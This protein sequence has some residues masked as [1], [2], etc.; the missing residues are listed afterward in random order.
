MSQNQELHYDIH[1]RP[2]TQADH[3][4]IAPNIETNDYDAYAEAQA[5]ILKELTRPSKYHDLDMLERAIQDLRAA[6]DKTDSLPRANSNGALINRPSIGC[7]NGISQ[8][9]TLDTREKESPTDPSLLKM[10]THG[11]EWRKE[12]FRTHPLKKANPKLVRAILR[13]NDFETYGENNTMEDTL[14]LE[15]IFGLQD[16][17]WESDFRRAEETSERALLALMKYL[18]KLGYAL[19]QLL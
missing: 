4:Q 5:K 7:N 9:P 3:N 13:H 11:Y 19:C 1:P 14:A 10:P 18:T 17:E 6:R 15:K 16:V 12:L 8:V 2:S